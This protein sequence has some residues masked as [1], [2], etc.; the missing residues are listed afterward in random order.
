[1][2]WNTVNGISLEFKD[3][4]IE[5]A[6]A[7]VKVNG[8]YTN[9]DNTPLGT[10]DLKADVLRGNVPAV[11]KYMPLVVGNDTITWLR[12]GLLEGKATGGQAVLKGPLHEF[13]F[14]ESKEH[15]FLVS[16]NAEDVL[17]D[18]YPNILDN[19]K[20]SP[21]RGAIWPLFE[22]VGGVVKFEG[23]GMADRKS[24]V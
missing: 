6:E 19:P 10:A 22:K 1:M 24:V 15:H 16:V 5:N 9:A 11:W 7:A 23:D 3:V 20:A 13:P 18:V 14:H 8:S 17:L 4:L 21:K 2:V 12:Y